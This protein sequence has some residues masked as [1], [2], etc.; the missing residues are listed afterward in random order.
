MTQICHCIAMLSSRS[1]D[2]VANEGCVCVC[3]RTC[4]PVFL[5]TGTIHVQMLLKVWMYSIFSFKP[6]IR[7]VY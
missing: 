2:F 6:N 7:L 3:V 1:L 5:S 4:V